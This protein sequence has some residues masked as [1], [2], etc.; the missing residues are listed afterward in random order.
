MKHSLSGALRCNRKSF[1][2]HQPWPGVFLNFTTGLSTLALII[3]LSTGCQK[4]GINSPADE[5]QTMNSSVAA[6]ESNVTND[7]SGLTSQTMWELQQARAATARYRDIKNAL[8]DEYADIAVDVEGM[9][10][11][12]MKSS[13]V[14]GVFDIRHPEILVYNK[15]EDGTQELVAVEYAVNLYADDAHTIKTPRPEGFTGSADVWNDDSGFPF[16]L[17]HAWVW[18]YNPDG[19]FNW[20]NPTV[21]LH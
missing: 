9:G 12:F 16:W 17:L 21:H 15:N 8:K 2:Q 4:E 14:D 6:V 7:Y 3:F 11:H 18:S 1:G 19:V 13:I 5:V 10:H 20:T